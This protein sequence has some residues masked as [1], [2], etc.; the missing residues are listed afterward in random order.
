MCLGHLKGIAC[1]RDNSERCSWKSKQGSDHGGSSEHVLRSLK[2]I[3]RYE[4]SFWGL[5]SGVMIKTLFV[6]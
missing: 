2:F 1:R 6:F 4:E 5:K 3:A